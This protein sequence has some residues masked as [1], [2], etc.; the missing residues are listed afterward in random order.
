MKRD[1]EMESTPLSRTSR[2]RV[3]RRRL[4]RM[5]STLLGLALAGCARG[6]QE[7]ERVPL[8]VVEGP[9][10][11]TLALVPVFINGQGPFA[12]ALDTGASTSLVDRGLVNQ[13]QLQV[14]E[15]ARAVTG[16]AC[17][18]TPGQIQVDQ[19]RV[20]EIELPPSTA[21]TLAAVNIAARAHVM[22]PMVSDEEPVEDRSSAP[23]TSPQLLA[24]GS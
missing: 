15:A 4:L 11:A 10:A 17:E 18:T 24:V 14:A 21:V 8:Q 3:S 5:S 22:V 20:G 19:W 7:G 16:V 9:Q 1:G 2:P 13:L 12:F 6:T 23:G